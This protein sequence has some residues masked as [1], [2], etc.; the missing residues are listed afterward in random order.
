MTINN[1]TNNNNDDDDNGN[2]DI[3]VNNNDVVTI[4]WIWDNVV[5]TNTYKVY[6]GNLTHL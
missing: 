6:N 1:N 4:S 5:A 3:E 2:E